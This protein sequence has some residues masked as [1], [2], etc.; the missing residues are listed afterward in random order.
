MTDRMYELQIG[1]KRTGKTAE[2][3]TKMIKRRTLRQAGRQA[4]RITAPF[5]RPAAARRMELNTVFDID[6]RRILTG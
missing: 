4:G 1:N 6:N 2:D 5:L 3:L